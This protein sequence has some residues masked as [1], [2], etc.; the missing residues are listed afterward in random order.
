MIAVKGHGHIEDAKEHRQDH[1]TNK[2]ELKDA[3]TILT[4]D[5]ADPLLCIS[6]GGRSLRGV[7]A[8]RES[9]DIS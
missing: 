5:S 9:A 3:R 7:R 4:E 6:F 2:R 8:C 1:R